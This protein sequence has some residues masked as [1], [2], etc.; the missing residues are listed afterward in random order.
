MKR[1][2]IAATL[3][4]IAASVCCAPGAA[5]AAPYLGERPPGTTPRVFAPGMVSTGN[6]HSWL[7]ISPDGREM[8]WNTVDTTT[9]SARL[10]CVREVGG[11]WTEPQPPSFVGEGSAQ[12][13]TFSPDGNRLY[14]RIRAEKGWA[15]VFVERL[16]SGWSAPRTGGDR[17][18][19]GSSFTR[20]GRAYFSSVMQTKTWN[21][22]I[23][24]AQV[25][26]DGYADITPLD[27]TINV[28]N[29]IDYTPCVSPDESFLLFS[30][31]RP[32]VG[33]REDMHV[34]VSFRA[35]DG[36]WSPPRRVSDVPGRFPSL[37]PDGRYLFFCGDDGNVYW[38]DARAIAALRP[39]GWAGIGPR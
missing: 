4:L 9:W 30:S 39:P 38:M 14:F 17:H 13:P 35:A 11:R 31:N 16:A 27:S 23:F 10:M 37:S 29:A 8:Y 25:T 28:P 7:A 3:S 12:S 20:T 36:S 24:S 2:T 18:A 15:T 19:C 1:S 32:L 22:G 34:Q 26:A 6:L 5:D 33:D 21:T